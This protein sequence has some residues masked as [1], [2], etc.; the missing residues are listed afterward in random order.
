M[1][2]VGLVQTDINNYSGS[3]DRRKEENLIQASGE[4]FYKAL[5]LERGSRCLQSKMQIAEGRRITRDG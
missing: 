1:E 4:R 5:R 2:L 3:H